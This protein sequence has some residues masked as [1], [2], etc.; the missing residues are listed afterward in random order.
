MSITPAKSQFRQLADA[1]RARIESG[2][3]PRG[4]AIPA[5]DDLAEEFGVS[6][7][8]VNR[9]VSILRT[10]GLVKVHRGRGTTVNELPVIR[11]DTA[12]RQRRT[13]RES[14]EARGAFDGEMKALGLTPNTTVSVDQVPASASVAELLGITEGD[15][16]LARSRVMSANDIPVQLATSYF[17][18]D[19]AE[20]SQLTETD[21]GPGG[22][23][24]RLAELGHAP[25]EFTETV[26]VRPPTDD[27]APRLQLEPDQRVYMIT[28][29]ARTAADRVVEVNEIILP[30]HQWELTFTWPAE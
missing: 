29:T 5:E 13:T 14:G 17:P 30:A 22:A 16:V 11:R 12:G 25:A 9:A 6:R 18:M 1:I 20:G 4:A 3:Y 2:E 8:V 28:R 15:T 21:T 24:S 23:Y 7:P 27:E 19:I 26:R 10:E